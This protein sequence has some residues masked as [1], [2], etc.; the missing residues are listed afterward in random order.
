M[1]ILLY[2]YQTPDS[3]I[4]LFLAQKLSAGCAIYLSVSQSVIPKSYVLVAREVLL[5]SIFSG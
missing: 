2:I 1:G 3:A 4:P 5:D